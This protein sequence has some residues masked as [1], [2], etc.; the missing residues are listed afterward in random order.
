MYTKSIYFW[1]CC[2]YWSFGFWDTNGPFNLNQ[3]TR[4]RDSKLKKMNL[5]KSGPC[6]PGWPLDKSEESEKRDKFQDFARQVKKLWDM[7]VTVIPIVIGALDSHQK[8]D[9]GTGG[10]GNQRTSVNH[11]NIQTALLR[12]VRI[13]R[14]VQETWRN[15]FSNSS[16]KPSTNAGVKNSQKS[17]IMIIIIMI[18]T[19]WGNKPESTGERRKIKKISR[20]G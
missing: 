5:P 8:I 4:P 2:R 19:T 6:R 10:L 9:A 3:T 20:K 1:N 15:C 7:K 12:S 18:N 14:R 17:K 13:L 11:P 16:V